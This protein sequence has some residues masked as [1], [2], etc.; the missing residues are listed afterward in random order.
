MMAI[1]TKTGKLLRYELQ[2]RVVAVVEFEPT[3]TDE[4]QAAQPFTREQVL[5]ESITEIRSENSLP[6]LIRK[7]VQDERV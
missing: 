3:S 2:S 1:V 5:A 7:V 6:E 4:S